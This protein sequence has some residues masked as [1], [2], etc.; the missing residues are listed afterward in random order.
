MIDELRKAI[1]EA[2]FEKFIQEVDGIVMISRHEVELLDLANKTLQEAKDNS[3]KENL[4]KIIVKVISRVQSEVHENDIS[5]G[6]R[7]ENLR[8]IYPLTNSSTALIVSSGLSN[9]G[10]LINTDLDKSEVKRSGSDSDSV[11]RQAGLEISRRSDSDPDK[12]VAKKDDDIYVIFPK[13]SRDEKGR[14][15]FYFDV[16]TTNRLPT[17]LPR[18]S[19]GDH[20]TPYVLIMELLL[21]AIQGESIKDIPG[22]LFYMAKSFFDSDDLSRLSLI[23]SE[24]QILLEEHMIIREERKKITAAISLLSR[25]SSSF[26]DKNVKIA[27]DN[28][29]ENREKIRLVIKQNE[30]FLYSHGVCKISQEIIRLHQQNE[31]SRMPKSRITAIGGPSKRE[32]ND[33]KESMLKLK[34]LN[35]FIE[36][37]NSQNIT[38]ELLEDYRE[39]FSA[40]IIS[41]KP[42]ITKPETV[43][44]NFK[45]FLEEIGFLNSK[46]ELSQSGSI[47]QVWLSLIDLAAVNLSAVG[48]LFHDLFDFKYVHDPKNP[49]DDYEDLVKIVGRHT[50]CVFSAFKELN[51]LSLNIKEQMLK[52]FCDILIE[53]IAGGGQG[54]GKH[55]LPGGKL[56]TGQALCSSISDVLLF[57]EDGC[58]LKSNIFLNLI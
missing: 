53:P 20:T 54:W 27:V 1:Q 36:L 9:V 19:Q 3:Q 2:D 58:S 51:K 16:N 49:Q 15:V 40:I 38:Q 43:N 39:I 10:A 55:R 11:G 42:T 14:L 17:G 24:V 44:E 13:I 7:E 5:Q 26:T 46:I 31:L 52:D 8:K 25:E 47:D 48:A 37:K 41:S 22:I 35:K 33:I 28:L 29:T 18:E 50:V 34:L 4:R 45:K 23:K 6:F 32:G 56:L 30:E 12:A 57:E 21:T